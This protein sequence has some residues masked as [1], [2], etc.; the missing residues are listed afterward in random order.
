MVFAATMT[1]RMLF[2]A[3]PAPPPVVTVT[4][5]AQPTTPAQAN[6]VALPALGDVTA[7]VVL[8][9]PQEWQV[10]S[11]Q[12][13]E[14]EPKFDGLRSNSVEKITAAA[15]TVAAALSDDTNI[16]VATHRGEPASTLTVMAVKRNG[17]SLE[18][19]VEAA[20]AKLELDGVMVNDA[21]I[22][23][24]WRADGLPVALLQYSLPEAVAAPYPPQTGLQVVALDASAINFIIFTF[25]TPNERHADLAS[26]FAEII[27]ATRF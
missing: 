25:T 2:P 4:P 9:L 17:L 26:R 19:Y 20:V 16:L 22:D 3:L 15:V 24:T 10:V 8:A 12:R 14:L 11:W 18:R 7:D 1:S 13:A 23:T 5:V 6:F 27:Q 21:K